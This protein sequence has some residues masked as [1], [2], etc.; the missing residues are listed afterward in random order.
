[1]ASNLQQDFRKLK[2]KAA[3][4]EK[5]IK[6]SL[7]LLSGWFKQ[8]DHIE[9]ELEKLKQQDISAGMV[10][11][12]SYYEKKYDAGEIRCV[13][14]NSHE[15]ILIME[16]ISGSAEQSAKSWANMS[17]PDTVKLGTS[18]ELSTS[19]LEWKMSM[20]TSGPLS[21]STRT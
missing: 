1:M 18:Q 5:I 21:R 9:Q 2:R 13:E 4:K 20:T 15:N 14:H 6:L 16:D 19:S 7:D 17:N 10:I 11:D 8:Y 12:E 3:E